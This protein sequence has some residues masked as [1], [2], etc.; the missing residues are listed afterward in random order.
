MMELTEA[1]DKTISAI[2]KAVNE[3]EF[4]KEEGDEFIKNIENLAKINHLR[5][6]E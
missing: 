4:T 2:I 5:E 1:I 3:G 6:E